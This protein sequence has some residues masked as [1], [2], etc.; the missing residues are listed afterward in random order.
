QWVQRWDVPSLCGEPECLGRYIQMASRFSQ[1]HP[2]LPPSPLLGID[3]DSVI[4]AQRHH[5]CASPSIARPSAKAI[6]I[7]ECGNP[8]IGTYRSQ[9][10]H[11]LDCLHGG[12]VTVLASPAPAES[13]LG[14]RA[15]FPMEEQ[16]DF[17][18]L[19]IDIGDDFL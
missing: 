1:V 9:N 13:E 10:P 11:H 4:V 2:T 17:A 16:D 15:S 12:I 14:V 19:G 3:R 8:V 5:T 6:P 18:C 7:E